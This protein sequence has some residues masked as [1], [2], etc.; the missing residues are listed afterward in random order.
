LLC[1]LLDGYFMIMSAARRV[2]FT[3]IAHCT[4]RVRW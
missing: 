2:V 1:A 3:Y 4:T